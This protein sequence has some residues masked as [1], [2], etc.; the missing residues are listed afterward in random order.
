MYIL[1]GS[2]G[3]DR[4]MWSSFSSTTRHPNNQTVSISGCFRLQVRRCETFFVGP[5]KESQSLGLALPH[6]HPRTETDQCTIEKCCLMRYFNDENKPGL[7][8]VQTLGRLRPYLLL[9]R[10]FLIEPRGVIAQITT[11]FRKQKTFRKVWWLLIY[12][13]GWSPVLQKPFIGIL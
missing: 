3:C 4:Y 13:C 5:V 8:G 1:K 6:P 2:D 10:R 11:F 12:L 7:P 9:K